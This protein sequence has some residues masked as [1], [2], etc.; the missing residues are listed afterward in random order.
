MA[1]IAFSIVQ[2]RLITTS[3]ENYNLIVIG[4]DTNN[5]LMIDTIRFGAIIDDYD[6]IS[7]NISFEIGFGTDYGPG[8]TDVSSN[9]ATKKSWLVET[10][11]VKAYHGVYSVG[12]K[13][14]KEVTTHYL[15]GSDEYMWFSHWDADDIKLT[16]GKTLYI[17]VSELHTPASSYNIF[18]TVTI[19]G[20]I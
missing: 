20:E 5:I 15:N 9:V 16:D 12:G 7:N 1:G 19:E 14:K 17:K 13:V 4:P 8:N 10:P 18:Y 11:A 6:Y 3:I 2:S